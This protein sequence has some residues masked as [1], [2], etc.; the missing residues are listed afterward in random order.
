MNPLILGPILDVGRDLIARFFP[1][2]EK[3]A[4][5]E[6]ELFRMAMDGELKQAI[7][8]LEINAREAAHPSVWVAGWRPGAGW[9]GV[10]G[11]AYTAILHPLLMWLST[12]KGW[13][14]PPALDSDLLWAV[15]TGML[16]LGGMRSLERIKGVIPRGK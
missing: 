8:Q 5:A 14:L 6:R 2:K 12:V 13:P 10:A 7:A 9:C 3:A 15:L 4:E 1:D 11:L 16:G